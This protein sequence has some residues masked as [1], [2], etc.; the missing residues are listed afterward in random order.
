[1]TAMGELSDPPTDLDEEQR[2][3]WPRVYALPWIQSSDFI[4][5]QMLVDH[6]TRNAV[7]SGAQPLRSPSA[8]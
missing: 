3:L 4:V 5:V 8:I 7:R 6:A 2:E 1:M